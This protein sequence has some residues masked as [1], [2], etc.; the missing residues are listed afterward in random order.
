VTVFTDYIA[1]ALSPIILQSPLTL[2]LGAGASQP[3]GKP[4]MQPFVRALAFGIRGNDRDSW[5]LQHL[6]KRCGE[7]LENILGELDGI[8]HAKSFQVVSD[9]VEGSHLN[10]SK[11]EADALRRSIEYQ[12]IQQYSDIS[13]TPLINLY[14]PLF[15]LIFAHVRMEKHCLP[16]FTTNYDTAIEEFCN[17]N[18]DYELVD[19][20][21]P[22]GR[23][24]VWDS[25]QFHS[26]KLREGKKNI[27]L[28]KLHGSVD[29]IFVKAKKAIV[30][31]QPFHEMA[32]A[33]RY[34]NVL[35][36]PAVHKVATD[37]PYFT[38]YDYYGRCCERS[39]LLLTIGYSFRDYDALAR[40]RSAMS[41]NEELTLALL[42]PDAKKVLGGLPIDHTREVLLEFLFGAK[43][44]L[45][46]VA[47]GI[48]N[49]LESTVSISA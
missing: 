20:F 49:L 3:L 47:L 28:F 37:D 4:T 48:R 12:I 6:I 25:T 30:R 38:A 42:G 10:I 45:G 35:I 16:I 11:E 41:L 5:V 21:R 46:E 26:F 39:R 44:T 13:P 2:F 23:D 31:T 15:D 34:K 7:D 40:L 8:I 36:Y 24:N 9:V 14:K 33:G 32:D 29:W 1:M 27:V 17:L 18:E 43:E 19:G 22:S